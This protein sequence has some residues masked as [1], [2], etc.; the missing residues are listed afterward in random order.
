[1]RLVKPQRWA[2]RLAEEKIL[3]PLPNQ[4]QPPNQLRY[5]IS[6]TFGPVVVKFLHIKLY[7]LTN[8]QNTSPYPSG[9]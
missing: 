7:F 9:L 8:Y 5:P 1:M 4:V 2:G 6:S 3:L